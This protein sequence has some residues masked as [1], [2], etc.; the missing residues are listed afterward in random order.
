MVRKP[1][2]HHS[3]KQRCQDLGCKVNDRTKSFVCAHTLCTSDETD[4]FL[5]VRSSVQSEQLLCFVHGQAKKKTN[6]S[7][8][9][10]TLSGF[11]TIPLYLINYVLSMELLRLWRL[12]NEECSILGLCYHRVPRSQPIT[13]LHQFEFI[14]L[15]I[16]C[17]PCSWL[18]R[19]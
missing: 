6:K 16:F 18:P 19:S 10:R 15:I 3:S 13:L 4:K 14:I 5:L 9:Q 11:I 17:V 8:Q 2:K 7:L 1:G 12:K